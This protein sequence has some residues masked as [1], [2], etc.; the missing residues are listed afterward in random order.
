[1]EK[2]CL[3]DTIR[4]L[5]LDLLDN[6]DKL[7]AWFLN[8]PTNLT[9]R[10][11]AK[12]QPGQPYRDWN[13]ATGSALLLTMLQ[14]SKYDISDAPSL[15]QAFAKD[16]E[17]ILQKLV[18]VPNTRQK[19]GR[20]INNWRTNIIEGLLNHFAEGEK[21]QL[22]TKLQRAWELMYRGFEIADPHY[23]DSHEKHIRKALACTVPFDNEEADTPH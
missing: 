17:H 12:W 6:K 14:P 1:M 11:A 23:K 19:S 9:A 3:H 21:T 2:G 10:H 22:A 15:S 13:N 4:Q 16:T 20:G 7:P 8:G 18:R 5:I